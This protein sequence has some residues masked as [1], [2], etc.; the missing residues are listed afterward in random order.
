MPNEQKSVCCDMRSKIGL[1]IAKVFSEDECGVSDSTMVDYHD[2]SYESPS[3]LPV[4]ISLSLRFCPWCGIAR[5]EDDH[6]RTI[7]VIRSD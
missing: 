7:E 5:K 2:F 6:R 3:H 1:G 4:A